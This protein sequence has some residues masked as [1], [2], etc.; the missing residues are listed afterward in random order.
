MDTKCRRLQWYWPC[1]FWNSLQY[2]AL[3]LILFQ[4]VN[5]PLYADKFVW[6]SPSKIPD[7]I[8]HRT[9]YTSLTLPMVNQRCSS[10]QP[11]FALLGMISG[12]CS[13]IGSNHASLPKPE[14]YLLQSLYPIV[15]LAAPLLKARQWL[16]FQFLEILLS[17]LQKA[18]RIFYC[19]GSISIAAINFS[20]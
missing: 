18:C 2:C 1:L 20:L 6:K 7:P 9:L 5:A 14:N 15:Q 4:I 11:P 12:Y 8:F 13:S 16:I 17:I 19:Y 10:C 3:T